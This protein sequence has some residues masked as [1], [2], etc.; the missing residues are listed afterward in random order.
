LL[1]SR[2]HCRYLIAFVFKIEQCYADRTT[3][4]VSLRPQRATNS[5]WA[6]SYDHAVGFCP[7]V[8]RITN[9]FGRCSGNFTWCCRHRIVGVRVCVVTPRSCCSRAITYEK[10][11]F[12]PDTYLIRKPPWP[13][14]NVLKIIIFFNFFKNITFLVLLKV[15]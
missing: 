1:F 8:I 6:M 4:T 7:R 13:R 2:R 15:Y 5:R 10:F 3:S 9:S 14:V 11:S 12:R